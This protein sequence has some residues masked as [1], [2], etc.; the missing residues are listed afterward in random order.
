MPTVSQAQTKAMFAAEAG[1]STLGIPPS[2]G[3]EMTADLKPGQVKR[4]P[5]RV[6]AMHKGGSISNRAKA[7]HLDSK[8]GGKDQEGINASSR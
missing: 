2:V 5:K 7:K 6:K 4:M 1:K 3:A 8:Y